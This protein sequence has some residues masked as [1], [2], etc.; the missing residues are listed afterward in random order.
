[1]RRAARRTVPILTTL[2]LLAAGCTAPTTQSD[3]DPAA[4]SRRSERFLLLAA[5]S[6]GAVALDVA[7]A[8]LI[9][10][11]RSGA[12]VWTDENG[13]AN[14]S[15]VV[16]LARC[17]DA[18][19]SGPGSADGPAPSPVLITAT[20]MTPFPVPSA[21]RQRVLSARSATDAV[22]EETDA[23]GSGWLR[24]IRGHT[25]ERVALPAPGV[26]WAE[27][28]DAKLAVT[29]PAT[30]AAAKST[31]TWYAH[32]G[33]GWRPTGEQVDRGRLWEACVADGGAVALVT[34][35]DAAL[36]LD[37]TR[38]VKLRT[39]L[40]A[41]G[42]CAVG[43]RSGAVTQRSV[44]DR[45]QVRTMIRGIDLDGAQTWTRDYESEA[46]VAVS[47]SGDHIAI[48]NDLTLDLIG[49]TGKG[50]RTIRGVRAARFTATGELVTAN[51][52]GN[53]EW[54]PLDAG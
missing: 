4:Q 27:S 47:P 34:G 31:I 33:S 52:H 1:M 41:P 10:F 18:I 36:L 7:A 39:D 20:T 6:D 54:L 48:V 16:C 11:D 13:P 12:R 9:G 23:A 3:P 49:K 43:L 38:R 24:I 25:S 53:V 50:T 8:K 17:P 21:V 35:W 15:G 44:D 46:L 5:T 51:V 37:R 19:V 14:G 40:P 26:V 30:A 45:G 42:E 29:F 28:P 2:T 32:D 22:I